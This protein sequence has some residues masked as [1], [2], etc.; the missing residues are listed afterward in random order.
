MGEELCADWTR[1]PDE[2]RLV[3]VWEGLPRDTRSAYAECAVDP[4]TDPAADADEPLP[5]SI[6]AADEAA[7]PVPA[8][9]GDRVRDDD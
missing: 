5:V 7:L 3:E 9:P 1:S 2:H 4:A 6:G 8:Y